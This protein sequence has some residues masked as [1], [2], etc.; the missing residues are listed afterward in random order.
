MSN[1]NLI[2][3]L[4]ALALLGVL[5]V[6]GLGAFLIMGS[7]GL[8]PIQSAFG[9]QSED[10]TVPVPQVGP[11]ATRV[12]AQPLTL[13][14]DSLAV[15]RAE[16]EVVGRVY[17]IVIPSVVN[18]SISGESNSL[19]GD[20]GQ[21]SGWVWDADGH[22]VTNNHV[23]ANAQTV[24]VT[25]HDGTQRTAEVI[26]TDTNSDLAVIRVNDLPENAP[27]LVPGSSAD[28]RVGQRVIAIGNPFGFEGTLTLG[29]VSA[30][31]RAVP[32]TTQPTES[33][34]FYNISNLIQTDAA[35]NPGNSG[36]PLLDVEGRVVG[37]NSMIYSQAGT[38]SGVGFAIPVDKVKAVVPQADR[39]R[40]LRDPLPRGF[41]AD[42]VA[43]PR[44]GR[45]AGAAKC[46]SW[47]AGN[48]GGARWPCR[49]GGAAR[50]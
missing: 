13:P 22:I 17:E 47:G 15:V 50:Q 38:N 34:G 25:F 45:R 46:R 42:P 14:S 35:I 21:G 30:T 40:F 11:T 6:C 39:H 1:R 24:I 48:R 5:C 18:V 26:G 29:V 10:G 43:D 44:P 31:E 37:V 32:L 36:G 33:G 2:G 27:P 9:G 3:A 28:L 41:L 4:A 23:V 12:P 7:G 20:L 8:A 49:S 16:E 19:F